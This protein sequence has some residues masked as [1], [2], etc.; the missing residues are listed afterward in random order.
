MAT[1]MIVRKWGNSVGVVFPKEIVKKEHL[2][3]EEKVLVEI[4]KKADMRKV[5]GSLKRKIS[6]QEFKDGVREGWH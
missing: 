6:G 1:E 2:K 3:P 5:F 4:V